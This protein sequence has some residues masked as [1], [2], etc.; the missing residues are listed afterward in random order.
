MKKL[1][2]LSLVLALCL[3]GC[4]AQE[5]DVKDAISS[6][7]KIAVDAVQEAAKLPKD[8]FAP[9]KNVETE[10]ATKSSTEQIEK[11]EAIDKTETPSSPEDEIK[12][13]GSEFKFMNRF[14][15]RVNDYEFHLPCNYDSVKAVTGFENLSEKDDFLCQDTEINS[16]N[17]FIHKITCKNSDV[18]LPGN[19]YVGREISPDYLKEVFGEPSSEWEGDSSSALMWDIMTPDMVTGILSI[20]FDKTGLVTEWTMDTETETVF[21]KFGCGTH[22]GVTV[23]EI[24]VAIKNSSYSEV[25]NSSVPKV[26]QLLTDVTYTTEFPVEDVWKFRQADNEWSLPASLGTFKEDSGLY[27]MGVAAKGFN[28]DIEEVNGEKCI[29]GF[30]DYQGYITLP[31]GYRIGSIWD[32][33]AFKETFGEPVSESNGASVYRGQYALQTDIDSLFYYIH[34]TANKETGI[35]AELAIQCSNLDEAKNIDICYEPVKVPI[36]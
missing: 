28:V 32:E 18:F 12:S 34:V 14:A 9:S 27:V 31:G 7:G 22:Y 6:G 35:I 25:A 3:T 19:I 20:R 13:S 33:A 4:D 17:Y 2:M 30:Y 15:F 10:E 11:E 23:E 1:L 24:E 26:N 29:I 8:E 16:D 36:E 5:K 21:D